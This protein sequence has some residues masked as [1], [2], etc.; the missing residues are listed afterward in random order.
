M[1]D[2]LFKFYVVFGIFGLWATMA[3][4]FITDIVCAI[5]MVINC[6]LYLKK[7]ERNDR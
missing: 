7:G 3:D 5:I 2:K 1:T 4:N 6:I